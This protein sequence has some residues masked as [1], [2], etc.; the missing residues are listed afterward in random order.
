MLSR[1]L[2]GEERAVFVEPALLEP[3]SGFF[4]GGRGS[5]KSSLIGE[6]VYDGVGIFGPVKFASQS[7][8]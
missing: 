6:L 3:S 2:G 5:R 8:D 7:R 1:M 4:D